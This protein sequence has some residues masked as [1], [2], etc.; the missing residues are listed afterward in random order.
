M[1][2]LCDLQN[3]QQLPLPPPLPEAQMELDYDSIVPGLDDLPTMM[4]PIAGLASTLQDWL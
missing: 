1:E 3:P 2:V 4:D